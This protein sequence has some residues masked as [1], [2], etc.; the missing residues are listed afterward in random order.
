MNKPI[1]ITMTFL[2]ECLNYVPKQCFDCGEKLKN[3]RKKKCL[4]CNNKN[5][6]YKI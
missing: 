5:I 3:N 4:K 6:G 1:P 2:K